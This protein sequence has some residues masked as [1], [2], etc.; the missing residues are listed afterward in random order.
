M[1]TCIA[2]RTKSNRTT[3]VGKRGIKNF[4]GSFSRAVFSFLFLVNSD[5][6]VTCEVEE[7]E[8]MEERATL[9]SHVEEQGRRR[10]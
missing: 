2:N 4:W 9:I 10:R 5:V 6:R 7:E 3:A 8:E 1:A